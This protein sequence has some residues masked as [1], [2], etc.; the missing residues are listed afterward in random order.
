MRRF[1]KESTKDLKFIWFYYN[2][3]HRSAMNMT[4]HIAREQIYQWKCW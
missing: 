4:V 2:L 3:E 1:F